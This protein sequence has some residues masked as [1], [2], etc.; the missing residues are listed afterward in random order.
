MSE[1]IDLQKKIKVPVGRLKSFLKA[2]IELPA[3]GERH[4]V[5]VALVSDEE[6]AKLN[7]EFRSIEMPTDVLSFPYKAEE[8]EPDQNFLGDIIISVD[9]A[10]QQAVENNLDLETEIKQ[11]ILHGLLHLRGYDHETDDGE[12]NSLELELRDK[13]GVNQ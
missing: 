13:L 5:S 11:L 7:I 10:A 3:I 12:M 9:R 4:L 2:A 8:F 6:I 1:L